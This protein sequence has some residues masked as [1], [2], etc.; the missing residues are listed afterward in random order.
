MKERLCI[1]AL[2][3]ILRGLC[4]PVEAQ[5]LRT[6]KTKN[7]DILYLNPT[8]SYIIP[9]LGRSSENALLYHRTLFQY[10]TD[11]PITVLLQDFSDFG[12]G[13]AGVNP[14]N[15]V[16]AGL[17][18]VSTV[19]ETLPANER[20]NWIMNHEMVHIVTLDRPSST[21]LFYRSLFSGKVSPIA[22]NPLTMLYS[23][24][25]APR[26]Y[27]TRWYREGIAAFTETWMA[28]G[29]GRA[30]GS[31]DEMVFRA[32]VRDGSYFYDP[33]GLES[34]G[35]KVD[36]QVGANAY[37]YGTRFMTYLAY[38]EGPEKLL[39]WTTRTDGSKAHFASAFEQTY[40]RTLEEGWNRWIAFEQRWQR[41]N[42][43][44]VRTNPVTHGRKLSPHILGSVSR[45]AYDKGRRSIIAAVNYPGQVPH[46]AMIDIDNGSIRQVCEVKGAALYD[47]AALAYDQESGTIFFTTDNNNWRDL[48]SVDVNTGRT[49]LLQRDARIGDLAFNRN[50]RTLWGVRHDNGYST[51]VRIPPPYTDWNTVLTW[52]YGDYVFDLD[53]APD[54]SS[55]TAALVDVTGRQRLIMMSADSLLQGHPV[56]EE[57]FDFDTS[58]PA[59]FVFSDDGSS[60]VGTSYYTGVSNVFRYDVE[61]KRM[62]ILSNAETGFFRPLAFSPDSL[63]VFEYTGTGFSPAMIPARPAEWVSSIRFLGNE[64]IERH[65]VLKDWMVPSSSRINIDSLTIYSG[66]YSPTENLRLVSAYPVVEG[67]KDFLAFGMRLNVADRIL[68]HGI[69]LTLSYTPNQLLPAVERFHGTLQYRFSGW[70]FRVAYNSAD[71]YDLFGPTKTG[72]KG[73]AV[74][75]NYRKTLLSNDPETMAYSISAFGY[76]DMDRLPDFQNVLTSFNRFF[77][78]G[79]RLNYEYVRKSLAAVD[80]EK[81]TRWGLALYNNTVRGSNFQLLSG[82]F[83]IGT[84]LPIDHSSLWL[85][86]ASGKSFGGRT[87][88]SA[89]FY[90]GGFG[91]NW[92]DRKE[93]KRYREEFSFPGVEI[94]EIGGANYAKATL[95]WLLPPV[96][97]RRFGFADFYCSWAH[98]T[99]FSMGIVTNLDDDPTRRSAIN[100]GAQLDF[101]LALFSSLEST[102]SFGYANAFRRSAAR[103]EEFMVSLKVLR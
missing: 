31:Y 1:V 23:Y 29:L 30:L 38:E 100:A 57:L 80:E 47:V 8:H 86:T 13:A 34:E 48:E 15:L 94:N 73:Y 40:G 81:G 65:P 68:L 59:N 66:S 9:H 51:I 79:G 6:V 41:T 103:S 2:F 25:T 54:G 7:F 71:F 14:R 28:G 35:T 10:E 4:S 18:P 21:D 32:M 70:R 74:G 33:V 93:V 72:R 17:A 88:P 37:L 58:N 75:V 76:G 3:L 52:D 85:R 27:S 78:V 44:S 101:K 82:T 53:V 55:L 46:I 63:I 19:F 24:L 84:L 22:E 62:E 89:N 98:L 102:L 99:L 49:A 11:E 87:D 60:L 56:Y 69:D 92:V 20:I 95:E 67:Y 91:N 36:F 64:T 77:S 16:S 90:F 12:N 45:A 42:L 61:E 97:F 96:R 26:T 5:S 50:D 43:D 83:D 39:A